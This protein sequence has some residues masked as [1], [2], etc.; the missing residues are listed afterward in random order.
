[1]DSD[2]DADLALALAL[3][4]QEAEAEAAAR[5][6]YTETRSDKKAKPKKQEVVVISSDEVED[7]IV[8]VSKPRAGGSKTKE[9][10]VIPK[11][12][13]GPPS[14]LGDR[15]QMERERLARQKRVRGPSPP[16][17][18]RS[19]SSVN[20]DQDDDEDESGS[21]GS[22]RKRAKL[23]PPPLNPTARA[24]PTGALLRIDSQHADSSLPNKPHCIR[25]SEALGPK[26]ELS[27]AILSAFAVDAPW[28]YG[29][30]ARD[31]PVVLVTDANMC[32]AGAELGDVSPTLKTSSRPG[33]RG[34]YSGCMRMKFMR[35]FSKS[36]ALRVADIPPAAPGTRTTP[37]AGVGESFPAM[38][39]RALRSVGVEEALAVMGRQG[40]TTLPLP[41]LL[42]SPLPHDSNSKHAFPAKHAKHP[43]APSRDELG[44]TQGA[45]GARPQRRRAVG[46]L[47]GRGGR[48]L[49]TPPRNR[50]DQ[51]R[52]MR[53]AQVLGCALDD[54]DAGVFDV[55][56][57]G[58]KGKGKAKA[59]GSGKIGKGKGTGGKCCCD[60]DTARRHKYDTANTTRFR[61][62]RLRRTTPTRT[63]HDSHPYL[64]PRYALPL[65][66]T[67]RHAHPD[68]FNRHLHPA[69][70]R[71]LPPLRGRACD[72][73]AGV[74]RSGTEEES[75]ERKRREGE[76]LQVDVGSA[77]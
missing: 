77:T 72:D 44:L 45:R 9:E 53:A 47:D 18:S 51:P 35:L 3:S 68:L 32:G 21:E 6:G 49:L 63:T 48:A 43:P 13:A 34:G 41:T 10:A 70:A 71:R 23:N 27:F 5:K 59:G 16:P 37:P 20:S 4:A 22:A 26:D 46:G 61:L 56:A 65:R 69:V 74:A 38:L 14:F 31:T 33:A 75:G 36:G 58:G 67:R 15:A 60:D 28:L 76:I 2:E 11:A 52:L 12:G 64:L 40:H 57:K 54:L 30:F 24:F 17:K 1:M 29:F 55:K 19:N 42:P 25:L 7:D 50:M 8:Q 73:A 62:P 66:P 39:A